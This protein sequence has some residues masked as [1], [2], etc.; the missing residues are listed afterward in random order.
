MVYDVRASYYS[1]R[2]GCWMLPVRV[3]FVTVTVWHKIIQRL[4]MIM[5]C[6]HLALTNFFVESHGHVL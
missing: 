3:A 2:H 1:G 5:V 6:G 4:Q